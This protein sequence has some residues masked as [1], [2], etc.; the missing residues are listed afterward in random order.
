MHGLKRK[1]EL[2][3][4]ASGMGMFER[5]KGSAGAW[6]D[7]RLMSIYG[8]NRQAGQVPMSEWEALVHPEDLPR[9]KEEI[10]KT[11]AGSHIQE[12][13]DFRVIRPDGALRYFRANWIPEL[14]PDG[15]VESVTGVHTDLTDRH[16]TDQKQHETL[17]R[18]A[19]VDRKMPGVITECDRTDWDNPKL[20]YISPKCEEI[21]GYTDQEFYA[22][23]HMIYRLHDPQDV[24][25]FKKLLQK[26]CDTGEAV[27]HRFR[28]TAR[29]GQSRWVDYHGRATIENG[30][31]I[32]KAIVLDVTREVAL[33][34]QMENEREIARRAQKNQSIGQLTGGVAH[35]FNNLLAVILGNL[36]LLRDNDAPSKQKEL[37]DAAITATLRGA[38]L[39][40]NMLAFAR[41]APLKPEVLKL[42]DVVREAKN[43]IGRTLPESVIVETSLLA[44]LWPVEADRSS[45]ESALLN[46][47]L[48]AKDAMG[49]HGNLTIETANIRIDE[50]YIDSRQEELVPGRYVML[51]VSDNGPG[52]PAETIGSIFE[53][54]FTTKPPGVGSGLGLSMTVGF[55]KQSGGTV[56]VYTEIGEGTTFKL[57]FPATSPPGQPLDMPLAAPPAFSGE[58]RKLLVAEDE[59]TVRDILVTILERAGY[60]VTSA[61]SGDEAF[62]AFEADPTFDLLVTDI[63]MP[64]T[65]QG[66]GLAKALRERWPDLPVLFMSG[67]ASEATVHGN[68]LRPEDVRLTKPVQRTELLAVVGK[69]VA[70]IKD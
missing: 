12:R 58:G 38:D 53:P 6:F 34:E 52:I 59:E 60:Q 40:R 27:F 33:Q 15:E 22:D 55:M 51:A 63:V 30:R 48:N 65:L 8:L 29:D 66:T 70:E 54:F 16:E 39:T 62:E 35:D 25:I 45:V 7:T 13:V 46:L 26:G 1:L 24:P 4:R 47:V 19:L 41:Q 67:Y 43:W 31:A 11:W 5:R 50:A 18:L 2:A 36:E 42:N 21:W 9:I 32:T 10:R 44:G 68:G 14:G 61:A 49:G 56:Q 20:L 3:M 17:E 57:Y 69:L 37:I 28:I 23:T 64:G